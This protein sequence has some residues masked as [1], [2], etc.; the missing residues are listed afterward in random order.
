MPD[1]I[2]IEDVWDLK[3]R[4]AFEKSRIPKIVRCYGCGAA[5]REGEKCPYCMKEREIGE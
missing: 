1:P 2:R 3:M 5:N 4:G